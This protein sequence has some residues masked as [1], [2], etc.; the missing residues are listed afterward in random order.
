MHELY[1]LKEKL[2]EELKEYGNKE[3][4]KTNLEVVE[5]LS[6]TIKNLGKIIENY[7]EEEEYSSMNGGSYRGSYERGRRS[8]E[9]GRSNRGGSYARKRDNMGRYSRDDEM[10]AELRELM[11]DAPDDR[12][13]QE[14]Q[15]F[16]Q[17]IEQM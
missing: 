15:R 17:K 9:R 8:Y 11:E 4:S 16:I 2:C 6:S 10:V 14:F 5:K 13:R 12:T 7:D 1:E 3:V